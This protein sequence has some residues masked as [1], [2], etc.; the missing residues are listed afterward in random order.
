MQSR[1][2]KFKFEMRIF[3]FL[4]FLSVFSEDTL[5]Y[6]E[7]DGNFVEREELDGDDVQ[8]RFARE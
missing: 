4:F 6:R 8:A 5:V 7:A 2:T 3:F 1:K